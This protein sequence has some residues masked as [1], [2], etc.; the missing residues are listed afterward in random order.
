MNSL[1]KFLVVIVVIGTGLGA[2]M[3]F[4]KQGAESEAG[5][6]SDAETASAEATSSDGESPQARSQQAVPLPADSEKS[7]HGADHASLMPVPSGSPVAPAETRHNGPTLPATPSI[8][9]PPVL[10]PAFP[11]FRP[12][13]IAPDAADSLGIADE[14]N[15]SINKSIG[16]PSRR[17]LPIESEAE[18]EV[19]PIGPPPVPNRVTPSTP[20]P[21]VVAPAPRPVE[22]SKPAISQ[23]PQLRTHKIVNGDTLARIARRYLGSEDRS[24]EILELNRDVLTNPQMLPLGRVIKIPP[25]APTA[26]ANPVKSGGTVLPLPPLVPLPRGA[27]ARP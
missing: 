23:P 15:A 13:E 11:S 2:A 18:V 4:R 19:K 12:R 25:H 8:R 14:H 26:D 21:T 17:D 24:A 3:L 5:S 9:T 16:T 7:A 10:P 27:F 20:P 1:K 22:V 6:A